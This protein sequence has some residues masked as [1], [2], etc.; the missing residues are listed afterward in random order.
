MFTIQYTM[1]LTFITETSAC[2][3]KSY[4]TPPS[5]DALSFKINIKVNYNLYV[6]SPNH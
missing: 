3:K 2:V 6:F 5:C 4:G 1:G